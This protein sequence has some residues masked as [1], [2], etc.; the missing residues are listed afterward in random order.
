MGEVI[1]P[2]AD[3]ARIE[4]HV[5]RALRAAVARGEEV[6]Q[7]AQG[8]LAP[9]VAAID[10]AAAAHRVAADAEAEAWAAVLAEDAKSDLAIGSVRDAMWAA[11]GRPRGSQPLEQ[12]FPEG[13]R[14][15]TSGDPRMQPVLMQVLRA[16]VL[17]AAA[18]QWSKE[19]RDGW[20]ATIE[21]LRA[22]YAAAVDA[23]RPAE[24]N[25]T[26]AEVAYRASVRSGQAALASFK[27]DLKSLGLSEAQI[28]DIIPDATKPATGGA[29]V[30]P[31]PP[32]P[33][34]AGGAASA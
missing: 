20:A 25:A 28:H 13:V 34:P 27:R 14:T 23:H 3:V 15:Y 16:R 7:A 5:R 18:P 26:V 17:T 33:A 31:A 12:V 10:V 32:A 6:A 4:D 2:K 22:S 19:M 30:P 11:L 9:A 1:G 21:T 29:P 8:R 24:A